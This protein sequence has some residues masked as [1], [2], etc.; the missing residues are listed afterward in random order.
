MFKMSSFF[1]SV[2]TSCLLANHLITIPGPPSTLFCIAQPGDSSSITNTYKEQTNN[3]E[4][5][6]AVV[7]RVSQATVQV[8]GNTVGAIGAGLLILLGITHDDGQNEV[9]LLARKIAGLRVFED[10]TGKMNL[11]ALET[12]GQAL[13]VSQFT[14]YGDARKGRR[15]SFTQAARPTVAEPL[16]R[17]FCTALAD[18]GLPVAQGVFQAT[19]Q[20]SLINDG[21]VTLWLD[22]EDLG[23]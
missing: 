1:F 20:V 12:G 6:R 4:R 16:Y 3:G 17:A 19:M 5:M 2:F 14:L 7:Q 9:E 22:T 21:P 15:P 18:Q 11:S 10:E 13:V 23:K 8:E